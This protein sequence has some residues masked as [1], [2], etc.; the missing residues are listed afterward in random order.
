VGNIAAAPILLSELIAE[1]RR[2]LAEAQVQGQG[3]HPRLRIEEAEIESNAPPLRRARDDLHAA[4]VPPGPQPR[5]SLGS[6]PLR[7]TE[8]LPHRSAVGA[9]PS[10]TA[11]QGAVGR[12]APPPLA[13]LPAQGLVARDTDLAREPQAYLDHSRQRHPYDAPLG[14]DADRLGLDVP[15]VPGLLDQLR[16]H[17]LPLA[18]GTCLPRCARPLVQSKG[19]D[20]R[21]QWAAG[22]PQRQDERDG[23]G[24][25][26]QAGE[27]RAFRRGAGLGA[28]RAAEALVLPPMEANIALASLPSSGTRSLGAACRSGVYACPPSSVGECTK[29]SRAGPPFAFQGHLTTVQRGAT[30]DVRGVRKSTSLRIGRDA[31]CRTGWIRIMSRTCCAICTRPVALPLPALAMGTLSHDSLA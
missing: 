29:R 14:L 11:Q 1:L 25:R 16:L 3:L 5:P 18:A 12:T 22:R 21:W 30:L 28:L 19:H 7:L 23:R 8:G 10:G 24:G 4:D 26:P 6:R 2:E 15:A 27:R 20:E 9:A 13:A 31:W 17:S